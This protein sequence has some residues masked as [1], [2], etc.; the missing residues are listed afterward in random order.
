MD[1]HHRQLSAEDIAHYQKVVVALNE[2]IRIMGEIDST[3]GRT[4]WLPI[5]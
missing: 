1:Y 5:K 3:Y 2:T 4:W